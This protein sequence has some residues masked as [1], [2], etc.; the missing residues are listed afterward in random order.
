MNKISVKNVVIVG[1]THGN[2]FTGVF[3]AKYWIKN[4]HLVQRTG[5]DT[6][7]IFANQ[8]AFKEVR[9]YIDRDLNRSCS[10]SVL[11]STSI[12]HEELL[13]KDLNSQISSSD[14][15]VDLHTTTSNMGLSLVVSNPSELTWLAAS[16][17]NEQ[18]PD[19]NVYR[20]K[21]DEEGAFVDSLG[22][23]G[24]AIEVGAVPQGVLR[25]D[26]FEKTKELVYTLLDFLNGD[27]SSKREIDIYDHVSLVDFPR[28]SDGE[29]IAI[30]HPKRQDKDFKLI[31]SGDPMFLTFDGQTVNYE[32]S[33]NLYGLFI[34]EAAYYEKGFAMCLAR[35]IEYRF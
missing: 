26:M 35:K 4:P 19:L 3:L 11:T 7:V 24:F 29:L 21:G 23:N 31:S 18:F 28:D 6:K 15:I 33:E 10:Q 25:A 12:L 8:K 1:G 34:N 13:A 16:H 27:L 17:L 22:V 20:W 14:F 9:R 30:V 2:E 32:G 5:L